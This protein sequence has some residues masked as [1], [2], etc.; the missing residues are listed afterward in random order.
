MFKI[1]IKLIL[2][3]L[4]P[5][6]VS[7]KL[8]DGLLDLSILQKIVDEING[9]T[10]GVWTAEVNAISRLP[11]IEQ[12]KLCG[13]IIPEENRNHSQAEPPKVEGT[14]KGSCTT[15]IEFD[16]RTKWSDQGQCGSCWAVSTASTYTDR[17]CIARAKKGQKTGTD[18]GSQFS[19]LDVL[20][21]SMSRDGCQ[22]GW[23]LDAWKWIQS[24]GVCTGTDI[25]TKS[26]CKPYPYSSGGP[27]PR[28]PSTSAKGLQGSTATVQAIKNEI[29]A[30][31]PV[32]ACFDVYNDF[33]SY[34][35][36][37]T[38]N[39]RKV[40]GHAVRIIGWGTQTCNGKSMPFWLIAN[41][42][43]TGW[44][45]KGL[46]KIRSGVNEVGIEKSGIAFGIPKI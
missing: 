12:K 19:A 42:W 17:Y 39:A 16:A 40:G 38:A 27:T 44:G 7:S 24:K 14:V 35:S 13:T 33:M 11:L 21:C 46:V 23:P 4:F 6:L 41:S 5:L 9:L 18:A 25:K 37:K 28:S 45:E 29:M 30:N 20:S 34:K 26:G 3:F 8:L 32:V 2:L 10:G 15:K 36:G 31:G 43:S 1:N 22:G